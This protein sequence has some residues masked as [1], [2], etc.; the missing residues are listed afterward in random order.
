[1]AEDAAAACSIRLRAARTRRSARAGSASHAAGGSRQVIASNPLAFSCWHRPTTLH[2]STVHASPSSHGPSS[3][4]VHITSQGRSVVVV[5]LPA[6]DVTV[7]VVLAPGVTVVLVGGV[8][9]VVVL[10]VVPPTVVVL[11]VPPPIVVVLVVAPPAVVVLVV[12]PPTG[13]VVVLVLPL[14]A[15][16]VLLV[17]VLVLVVVGIGCVVVV[18]P[19][20]CGALMMTRIASPK[21]ES[22]MLASTPMKVAIISRYR[23]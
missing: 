10:V 11:V 23:W 3:P 21:S 7:V 4:K 22:R 2:V 19:V 6:G 8:P 14:P 1:L 12:E 9:T 20:F 15:G 13:T 17:V 16:A 18:V 5:V